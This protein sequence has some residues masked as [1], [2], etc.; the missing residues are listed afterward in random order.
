M[1]KKS[2]RDVDVRGKTVLVRVDFNVPLEKGTGRVTDATRLRASLP[3]I[4]DLRQRGARVVLMSHLGRPK[5]PPNPELSLAPVAAEL[6]QLLGAPVQ[7]APDC[8]GPEVKRLVEALR[9]GEVLLLENLRFH[10]GEEANDPGFAAE[11]TSLGQVYV[12][13]AF[14]TAHRAHAST[15]GVAKYLPA[16]AGFLMEKEIDYL[17]RVVS[18]PQ[19]PVA[20]IIGGAN[21]KIK[22]NQHLKCPDQTPLSNLL[23]T[24]ANRAGI[25]VEKFGDDGTKL[26]SEV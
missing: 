19:A 21:G 5:G 8:V 22:G 24:L 10:P 3:T 20:A 9:P 13:D 16:V 18:D 15:A 25:P 2:V 17:G 23:L 26:I 6:E 1:G 11:L 12:N 4:Q 14:G 7:T